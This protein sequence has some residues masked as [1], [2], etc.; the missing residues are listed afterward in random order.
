MRPA[1]PTLTLR[2][3]VGGVSHP[4]PFVDDPPSSFTL[5][6]VQALGA[7]DIWLWAHDANDT[8]LFR[9]KPMQLLACD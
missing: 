9:T 5:G 3:T 6:G 1:M 8:L 4:V 2:S 7:D